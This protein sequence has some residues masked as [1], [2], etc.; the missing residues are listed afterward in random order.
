MVLPPLMEWVRVSS[1]FAE[2]RH[3]T[4]VD[5]DDILQAGQ[6]ISVVVLVLV[7]VLQ[8]VTNLD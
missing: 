5:N 8:S 4:H 6:Y 2:Y 7:L 1:S 3:S